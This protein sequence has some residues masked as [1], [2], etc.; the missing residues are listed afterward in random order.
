ML[1]DIEKKVPRKLLRAGGLF[2]SRSFHSVSQLV[3]SFL[4]ARL[5]TVEDHGFY[6]QFYARMLVFQAILEAG[7]QY[8]IIRYLS[9]AIAAGRRQEAA[10]II[11]A[12][13]RLKLYASGIVLALVGWWMIE[14]FLPFRTGIFPIA[15]TPDHLL[16]AW[17]IFLAAVGLSFFSYF[18]SLLV[19]FRNYRSLMFWIPATGLLRLLVLFSLYFLN[20][21][22]LRIED[23]LFAFMAGSFLAWPFYFI[24]FDPS[25]FFQAC[26][27]EHV[28]GWWH[29]LL[30]YNR[31]ILLASFF[32]ML[33]D[34]MEILIL[35]KQ[36][37][38]AL[39]N[40]AR[41][42]MQGFAI[43]LAT[44]QSLI[45]PRM[46]TFTAKAQYFAFFKRL[47]SILFPGILLLL[48]GF[49][50]FRWFIPLWF[51]DEYLGSVLLFYIVYPGFLLRILFAPLGAA[52][53]ALDEPRMI[54]WEA[55]LRMTGGI[56]ANALLI[57]LF[58]VT[59]AAI[60][61]VISQFPGWIFLVYCY[62]IYYRSGSF[63]AAVASSASERRDLE[64]DVVDRPHGEDLNES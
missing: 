6:A 57:P 42:P 12:S 32:A 15:R 9:P 45:L 46:T 28:R 30:R 8:S 29:R 17:L 47:Y 14:G 59:G 55:G 60:S 40:A 1:F 23:V 62:F 5:L 19:S 44:M 61:S 21:G 35:Q 38:V 64:A 63:P 25:L 13:M 51:G 41:M 34:Y 37:D 48:P 3:F 22:E 39:Y 58:G 16:H 10:E 4:A 50:I 7:L 31:W 27:A 20:G 24:R 26:R 53:F 56:V 49:W 54:A 43:L 33:S 11:R 36:S 52:L 18:D 2:F